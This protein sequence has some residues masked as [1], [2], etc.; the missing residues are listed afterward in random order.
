[1][2]ITKDLIKYFIV[3]L[4]IASLLATFIPKELI[5]QYVG[6]S[7]LAFFLALIIGIPL[8]VCE[9]E[10][11][12]VTLSLITLGLGQGP[13]MTFLLGAVGTCIPTLMMAKKIIGKNAM[14]VYLSYWFIFAL[15]AGLIFQLF[16][17]FFRSL[18]FSKSFFIY[19]NI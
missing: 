7:G 18:K 19:K 5:P 17:Y 11:I 9:G 16:N 1:M 13:A 10:E 2:L 3:G 6:S 15:S 8:Y 4:I 12:P 14:L